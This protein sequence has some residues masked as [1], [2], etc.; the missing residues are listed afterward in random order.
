MDL[1]APGHNIVS[2]YPRSLCASTGC[3]AEG[4]ISYGYHEFS[5]TSQAAPFV[6]GVAALILA[7]HPNIT[8][9]AL[10]AAILNNVETKSA[11]NGICVTG[12]RLNAY[13]ALA[14]LE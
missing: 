2:C 12:G 3:T 7:R 8:P 1:F 9:A 6:T 10:K 5:G 14:A 11:F 13:N 4:H